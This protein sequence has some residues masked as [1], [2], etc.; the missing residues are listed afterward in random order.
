[1]VL[2]ICQV[3][4]ASNRLPGRKSEKKKHNE[5]QISK[6]S[7]LHICDSLTFENWNLPSHPPPA[8]PSIRR[9]YTNT[10]RR[11][12]AV[13]LPQTTAACW[14]AGL[15]ER[16]PQLQAFQRWCRSAGKETSCVDIVHTR[17][18]LCSCSVSTHTCTTGHCNHTNC[19]LRKTNDIKCMTSGILFQNKAPLDM[20]P[21]PVSRGENTVHIVL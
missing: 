5:V 12:L 7:C 11:F 19:Q 15:S 9:Y 13:K 1:M 2:H 10:R 14:S 17:N 16:V 21:E 20:T 8:A 3:E 4:A 18:P 6:R